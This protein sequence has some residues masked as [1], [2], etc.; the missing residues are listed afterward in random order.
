MVDKIRHFIGEELWR[1][2]LH[3]T[4]RIRSF[5]IRQLRIII[6]A[7]KGFM[8]DRVSLRAS[9]LTFYTL[10]SVVPIVAMAFGVAKGFG[11]KN[12]ME[13]F[14]INNFKGQEE[15]MNYII[16]LSDKVLENV[17][18]G[19]LAGIGV[20]VLIWSV[21]QVLNNIESSFNAIWQVKKPRSVFRKL[22]DYLSIM[23]IGPFLIIVSSS[24]MVYISTRFQS[25]TESYGM[26]QALSPIIQIVVRI[27][28]YALIWLL[29]TL[30]YIIL[31]NTRV[32]FK[33]ALV[34]GILAGT[35]FQFVQ[36]A[37]IHFQIGVSKYSALYG[38]FAALPLFLIWLQLSWLIVLLGA[39][40]SFAYQN[41]EK[42]EL[43]AE[44]L[45]ISQQNKRILSLLIMHHIIRNFQVGEE[46][47]TSTT[48]SQKLEIPIRLVRDILFDLNQ[49]GVLNETVT[50]IPKEKGYQPAIDI[51]KID[52]QFVTEKIDALGVDQVM[53][54]ESKTFENLNTIYNDIY[55]SLRSSSTNV[56]LKDIP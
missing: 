44:S 49:A 41:V 3:Q 10:L 38:T 26:F 4:S 11:F 32:F 23:L 28:P 43:E 37:Y 19:L 18:G 48:I 50:P 7:F 8:E 46:P 1:I 6:L 12:T 15:V 45:H 16:D 56:L 52:I 25:A 55:S 27:V 36:W 21:M 34:A 9:A 39:E 33:Y 30:V 13:T 54:K 24:V 40:I 5:L 47:E 31:P 42:Y 29:F 2:P 51:N 53:V 35:G 20:V 14:I 22:S 17:K